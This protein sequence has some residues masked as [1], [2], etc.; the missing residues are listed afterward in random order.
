[1]NMNL[2][3]YMLSGAKIQSI[4]DCFSD[5]LV[6]GSLMTIKGQGQ[7]P[8][9]VRLRRSACHAK[10]VT[11]AAEATT[12]NSKLWTCLMPGTHHVVPVL[13]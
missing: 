2:A 4:M 3:A 7:T 5:I 9:R 6:E 12:G 11:A 13:D 10:P 8:I 1:M